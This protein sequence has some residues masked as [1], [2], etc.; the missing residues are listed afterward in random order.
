MSIKIFFFYRLSIN[1]P[2]QFYNVIDSS[3]KIEGGTDVLI[4]VEPVELYT[5]DSVKSVEI[6]QRKCR[7]T[8]EV[9]DEM[10]L[11]KNYTRNACLFNCMYEYR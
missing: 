1:A 9:P 5:D 6:E 7:M 4:R 8:S 11:F 3:I 2:D 10:N